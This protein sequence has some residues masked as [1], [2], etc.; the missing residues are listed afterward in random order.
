MRHKFSS[1][2]ALIPVLV[3]WSFGCS[4]TGAPPTPAF[5]VKDL[6]LDPS[7]LPSDWIP[8][9]PGPARQRL[10]QIDSIWISFHAPDVFN[11]NEFI[12]NF[13]NT[14]HASLAFEQ[15]DALRLDTAGSSVPWTTPANYHYQSTIATQYRFDCRLEPLTPLDNSVIN[16]VC[17]FAGQYNQYVFG[18]TVY[19]TPARM[20]E[21]DFENIVRAID[22][23]MRR[24]K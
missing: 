15:E 21:I 19:A 7:S 8:T 18:L 24:V 4:A 9:S 6:L 22:D 3:L 2:L 20:Q 12:Y 14:E 11:V 13:P 1:W 23:R 5:P 10:G 16:Q 17:V